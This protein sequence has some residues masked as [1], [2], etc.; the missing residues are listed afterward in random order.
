MYT[1]EQVARAIDHAVLKP[2]ATDADVATNAAMCDRTD[3]AASALAGVVI[4]F[5]IRI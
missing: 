2:F 1:K 5:A 3:M 4:P